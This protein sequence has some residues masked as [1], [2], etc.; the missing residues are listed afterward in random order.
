[1]IIRPDV[2]EGAIVPSPA[3]SAAAG[4]QPI[5]KQAMSN[6]PDL[7]KV[8]ADRRWPRLSGIGT[9]QHELESRCPPHIKI[10]DLEVGG[11]IGSPLSPLRIELALRRK[12][13]RA[14]DVFYSAGFMP[15]LLT[16]RPVVLVVHDLMHR[17]FYGP[18]KRFYYDWF[19]RFVYRRC[20][21]ICCVSE[22][23]RTE[24]LAWSGM[25]PSRV[26][27]VHAMCSG[28]FTSAGERYDP[29]YEYVAY[30]GN[31]RSYKNLDRLIRAY[32]R[33]RLAGADVRLLI[34]GGHNEALAVTAQECGVSDKVVF[35][36][37]LAAE[38]IPK[39]YRG[40]KAIAYVS[41]QEGFGLPIL[42][43][44][45]SGVPIVTSNVT[46]M[47]EVAGD[48]AILVD[49]YSVDDIARGLDAAVF[50]EELRT[51]KVAGG[52]R[53]LRDFSWEKSAEKLWSLVS[54]VARQEQSARTADTVSGEKPSP[55]TGSSA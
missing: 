22:Y 2:T 27:V 40:A 32:A 29:G 48:A 35:T 55:A 20:A 54:A 7:Q 37:F 19:L 30:C 16:S 8:Y 4:A 5:G 21:A 50:D 10:I 14:S 1:M 6:H 46:S 12:A 18:V 11:S 25:D 23:T 28:E 13:A 47:P 42:E 31:H 33:S 43:A 44:F 53:R 3:P 9:V 51:A 24:F 26:H 38:D 45:A 41:L 49:P 36:G 34:T 39:L 52:T 15:P 17:Q